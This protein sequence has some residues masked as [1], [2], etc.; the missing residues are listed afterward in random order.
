MTVLVSG[1]TGTVGRHLVEELLSRGVPV[2]ALSRDPARARA[3]LPATAEVVGGDLTDPP[4]LASALAG[5]TAAHLLTS[6][7]ATGAPLQDRGLVAAAVAAGVRS[8][9]L[10]RGE[11][12][13]GPLERAV[14]SSPLRWTALAP[15]EFMANALEWAPSVRAEGVVREAFADVPSAVV[16]EA[17]I[18]AV[19]AAALVG[20]GHHG[21]ELW[22]TGPEALTLRE[23]VGVLAAVLG[24]GV[25]L[26]ELS[27]DEAVA[28]WRAAGFSADDVE[29]FLAVRTDPPEAGRTVL[30][31]VAEVTGRPART[32]A[33]WVREH[34]AAFAP[35]PAR[36]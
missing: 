35:V 28:Q 10:L 1:A 15:V 20:D 34:A 4:G 33:Q 5:V 19:A 25:R 14:R 32:F 16:H 3:A 8:V 30:P 13:P 11:A 26:A 17:D 36:T 31:T 18:A 22:L 9:T 24:R 23:R 12:E 6:D 29:F 2:R 7:G 21:R 27:R